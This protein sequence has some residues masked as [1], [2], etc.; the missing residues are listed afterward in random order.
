MSGEDWQIPTQ[1]A[2]DKVLKA[3]KDDIKRYLGYPPHNGTE[4]KCKRS[5]EYLQS[6]QMRYG[7]TFPELLARTN[8]ADLGDTAPPVPR[9]T[10]ISSML[11]AMN[12]IYGIE[13][14]H[15]WQ[16]KKTFM[17]EWF[18]STK[19]SDVKGTLDFNE[20]DRLIKVLDGQ[21]KMKARLPDMY[22][23]MFVDTGNKHSTLDSLREELLVIKLS[24]LLR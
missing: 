5:P 2:Y 10:P 24:G 16:D 11:R 4:N 13:N 8:M 14:L 12:R 7:R 19:Q 15:F 22:K 9:T 17:V 6:L 1:E 23:V 20:F 21:I 18:C 3:M